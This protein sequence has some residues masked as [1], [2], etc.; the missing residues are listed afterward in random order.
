MEYSSDAGLSPDTQITATVLTEDSG[1]D[2]FG[3][4]AKETVEEAEEAENGN[5]ISG[6][7]LLGLFD[8]TIFDENGNTIQ[9]AEDVMVRVVFDNGLW[10]NAKAYAV[11]F[12]G[13]G[14]AGLEQLKNAMNT[15]PA[16]F[17]VASSTNAGTN[18]AASVLAQTG[19]AAEVI[20]AE[21]DEKEVSFETSGF[22][23]YAIV[24]TTIEKTVLASDGHNYRITVTYEAETGIPADADLAVSEI[25][26]TSELYDAYVSRSE[27]A[28]GME[29]GAVDY[30]RLFD[31]SIV[32]RDDHG[33]KYQPADGTTVDVQIELADSGTEELG[34]VHFADAEDTGSVVEAKTSGQTVTFAAE[35][36]S[37]YS[38]VSRESAAGNMDLDG[39]TYV[40]VA[41]NN[42]LLMGTPLASDAGKLA[43]ISANPTV[44]G[45]LQ[46]NGSITMWT[47]EAVSGQPGWY[48]IS[49]AMET[50]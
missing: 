34:V 45:T 32:D 7:D 6:T 24:G 49:M 14:P 20:N 31:I 4:S 37:V 11:H 50:I 46:V 38:V 23:V 19:L 3:T 5:E 9:P 12:P 27:D 28:L 39:K 41:N 48:Y 44:G 40:L 42:A 33:V 13:T 43:A 21:S 22:S 1:Y 10:Q 15:A 29:E 36:F 2:R 16:A 8:L 18:A 35:G 26:G 17:P 47:F 30:I 25:L